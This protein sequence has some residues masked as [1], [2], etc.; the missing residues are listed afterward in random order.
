[1]HKKSLS[2]STGDRVSILGQDKTPHL[3]A[4][5]V[6]RQDRAVY[7]LANARTGEEARIHY[8]R[9][10]AILGKEAGMEGNPP[11]GEGLATAGS[12]PS[13]SSTTPEAPSPE[14]AAPAV[15]ADPSPGASGQ[16]STPA[17]APKGRRH[18]PP[19]EEQPPAPVVFAALAETGTLW[20]R[21]LPFD[22]HQVRAEA[23]YWI[24]RDE[25][26]GRSFNTYNG[27]LGRR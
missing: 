14:P 22:F 17:K 2:P 1:M 24:A 15:E 13:A 27:S 10:A 16:P 20:R 23:W 18:Q 11:G 25:R 9:I 7:I 26:S 3:D 5:L 6:R 4:F 8:S 12:T 21:L 19:K